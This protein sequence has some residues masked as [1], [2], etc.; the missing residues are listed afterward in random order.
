MLAL[1]GGVPCQTAKLIATRGIPLSKEVELRR[2]EFPARSNTT[3]EVA[4]MSK[5]CPGRDIILSPRADQGI[6]K[7]PKHLLFQPSAPTSPRR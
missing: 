1:L 4:R 7:V 3:G 6:G 5:H 2:K